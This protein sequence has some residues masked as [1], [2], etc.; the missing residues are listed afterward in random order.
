MHWRRRP[1]VA[2]EERFLAIDYKAL[3]TVKGALE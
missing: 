3:N 1:S 2:D